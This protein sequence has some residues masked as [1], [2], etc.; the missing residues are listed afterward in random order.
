[1]LLQ[2]HKERVCTC[3]ALNRII[4]CNQ[5]LSMKL[6]HQPV[7]WMWSYCLHRVAEWVFSIFISLLLLLLSNCSLYTHAY[8]SLIFHIK[9]IR[10]TSETR[11]TRLSKRTQQFQWRTNGTAL[12][13]RLKTQEKHHL[14]CTTVFQNYLGK[15]FCCS[16]VSHDTHA[17]VYAD[18][19]HTHTDM[20]LYWRI[21]NF[22]FLRRVSHTV[23]L[24]LVWLKLFL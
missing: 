18:V 9:W 24:S 15:S 16:F 7:V 13:D 1:M 17:F 6:K 14:E 3:H 2:T 22:L 5:H 21:F 10:D 8:D 11:D 23:E 4:A 19:A 20:E 12:E